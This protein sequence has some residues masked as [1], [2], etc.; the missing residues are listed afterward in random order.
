MGA[1]FVVGGLWLSL[2][3]SAELSADN[4]RE[5]STESYAI[6]SQVSGSSGEE[7]TVSF[8]RNQRSERL[9][10]VDGASFRQEVT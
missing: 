7:A 1:F 5:A 6:R 2:A 9:D 4:Y 8:G 3:E 10:E